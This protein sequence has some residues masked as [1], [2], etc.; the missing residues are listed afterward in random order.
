MVK[1][2]FDVNFMSEGERISKVCGVLR[3]CVCFCNYF[4]RSM[5][6]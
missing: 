1:F 5:R 2:V 3:T 6:D 4:W